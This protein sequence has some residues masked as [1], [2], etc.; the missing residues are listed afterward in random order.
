MI[1]QLKEKLLK[2]LLKIFCNV[3]EAKDGEEA[4]KILEKE[5]VDLIFLDNLLKDEPVMILLK[6]YAKMIN[7][8]LSLLS[9]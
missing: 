7:I 4:F 2:Q 3:L 1:A 5:T 9:S 6:N 8:L